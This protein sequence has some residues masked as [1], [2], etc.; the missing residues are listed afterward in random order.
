[1]GPPSGKDVISSADDPFFALVEETGI[2]LSMHGGG[3]PVPAQRTSGPLPKPKQAVP[4]PPIRDQESVGI[5]RGGGLLTPGPLAQVILT[6]VL[7]RFPKLKLGLIE[8]SAGWYPAFL[9]QLDAAWE[10]G[11]WVAPSLVH[12]RPS[13]TVSN[14]K[15][16]IDRELQGVKHR[17]LIGVERVMFGTDYPHVGTFWPHTRFYIDLAFDGVPEDEKEKILWSNGAELYGIN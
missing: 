1:M 14:V 7:E 15:I 2:V 9:E 13:E 5:S 6:G 8:T 10:R 11:R 3:S 4:Q 12:K 17:H 16:S